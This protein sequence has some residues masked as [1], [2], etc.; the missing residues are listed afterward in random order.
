M[1]RPVLLDAENPRQGQWQRGCAKG[2]ED[3]LLWT[4]VVRAYVHLIH[5]PPWTAVQESSRDVRDVP[6][7]R[8]GN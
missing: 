7:W 6:E 3:A 8:Y 5:K 2:R 4:V 1:A